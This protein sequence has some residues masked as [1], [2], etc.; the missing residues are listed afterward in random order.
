MQLAALS[1]YIFTL[2]LTATYVH[3]A[4]PQVDFDRMGTVA[5]AGTFSGLDV[6][7]NNSS[8]T[9]DSS[10]SSVFARSPSG[11]LTYLGSTNA[12]GRVS[13]GCFLG[14]LF[15]LTGSFFSFADVPAANVV[16]YSFGSGRFMALGSG[17]PN[18]PVD[19]ILC[20][21]KIDRVW[22]GGSFTSPGSS[23]AIWDPRSTSWSS[24][25]FS[26]FSGA[27]SRVHSITT[28]SSSSSIF[29]A[30]SFVTNFQGNGTSVDDINN[31]NVPFS[32]G[33]TALSSSL[34]PIPLRDA[35]VIGSP[36]SS[37]SQFNN[38]QNVL[39]PT[40][41][42]GP[43][44][45]WFAAEGNSPLITVR[46]FSFISVNGVRLG[47]TFL[48]NHGT[49]GFSVTTI[50]DNKLQNLHFKDPA[51]G[52]MQTCSDPCPLSTNSSLLYQD[53]LFDDILSI[54]GVQINLSGFTGVASG[55]HILQLLSSGAFVSA[56][57]TD[58]GLSCFASSS[59]NVT[60][61]G[62]WAVQV[63]NTGIPGT[64]QRVAVANVNVGT[65]PASGPSFAWHPFI[66]AFG[67]YDVNLLVPGCANLQDCSARTT[68]KIT[69][70][71]E[72]GV[73]PQVTTVS[74]Q[75]TEDA[76]ITVYSGT[77]S[78]SSSNF[79]PTITMTLA[80]APV[81]SGQ[82]G[83]F[84]LVADRVQ[85][86]LKTPNPGESAESPRGRRGS[87]MGFGF[88]EWPSATAGTSINATSIVPISSTTSLDD[89]GIGFF[90]GIRKENTSSFASETVITAVAHHPSGLIFLGGNFALSS[91]SASGGA[92]I[93]AFNGSL[94]N[95]AGNGLNGPV[96][97]LLLDGNL[98]FV[99]GGFTGTLSSSD[100]RKLRGIAVY[101]VNQSD[102]SPLGAG[103]DG[104]VTSLNLKNGQL[105]VVGNF[106][107]VFTAD[108]ASADAAGFAVW[109]IRKRA[110]VNSGGFVM[111]GM[112][113]IGNG[114]STIQVLAG[115]VIAAR[116]YGASG[117][118]FL[119][120][121]DSNGPVV[122]PLGAQLQN[123]NTTFRPSL[124]SQ[125]RRSPYLLSTSDSVWS[126]IISRQ[127]NLTTQMPTLPAP[128]PALS[129]SILTGAF[130]TNSSSSTDIFVL[131]GNFSLHV[132]DTSM[133]FQCIALYSLSSASIFGLVGSQI[134]GLVRTLLVDGNKLYIGGEFRIQDTDVNGLA[135]YDLSRQEWSTTG[136]QPLQPSD[137]NN[138]V[139]RSISKSTSRPNTIIVAGSFSRAGSLPCAA[140]CSY[141][142]TSQ[143]WTS[144]GT[145]LRGEI[146][147]VSYA[148]SNQDI[149]VVSG[150]IRLAD[151]TVSNVAQ[152]SFVNATW[153]PLGTAT[154]LPGPV[155]AVEV[156]NK[157]SS[158]IFA[159]GQSSDRA[160]TFLSF[161]NGVTWTNLDSNLRG[162]STITQLTMVPLQDTHPN[163]DVIAG[164]RVLLISGLLDSSS[165][166]VASCAL[167]DGRSFI[168]YIL[169][170]TAT[171]TPGIVSSVLRSISSFSFGR[172]RFLATG[173]V[174]LISIAISAGLIFMLALIGIVWTILSRRDDKFDKL[175]GVDP[176]EDG[177]VHHR[178]SSLLEH[179]NAA[180]RKTILLD[181]TTEG[182]GEKFPE[183]IQD[184][185]SPDE[186][187]YIRPG[188]PAGI[189]AAEETSRPA[190]A[191]YSFDGTGEGELPISAGVEVD[192][193]DDHDP[194]WW[195][196]RDVRTG[197][198]GVVP[199]AYLY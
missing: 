29:F 159:A 140:I 149:L 186:S 19:A 15:Y 60:T 46:T 80:D 133:V 74:Q 134:D 55:L 98:L 96:T 125:R 16:S 163:T 164:D 152:F 181:N 145:G 44:N 91:G 178:P 127:V 56:I 57:D 20:D 31:P 153:I 122:A 21:S 148:G 11:A 132:P 173:V 105:Q 82:N 62:N 114:S 52:Q 40:G 75:N 194:A 180:T 112:T 191:R 113:Y 196:A 17:G 53:F 136:L 193:L 34:V 130:W 38:I 78:S 151:E 67:D 198:E 30:G 49:T 87:K 143:Q 63:A 104:E 61:N 118:V 166:G 120:N 187:N 45:T 94:R 199:A 85:L 68:A 157:N 155:T 141:D 156:N 39:C 42:D 27:E 165:F 100:A 129:P 107:H 93:I 176:D 25:P 26:S 86:I 189:I 124:N 106:T 116:Q 144:L 4:L 138:V 28:N 150:S 146:A 126:E 76:A 50:P 102:W 161:W 7:G 81:G 169:S 92:N 22:V 171:G 83:Q 197:R 99:G 172:R 37:D 121:G 142:L 47:N 188:S 137:G 101:D 72:E 90:E 89:I 12:G 154:D 131:G 5:L 192:V 54:T 135:I 183:D 184:P 48:Q 71:L 18:G 35:Q 84:N 23:V 32:A 69:I 177:S 175:D 73:P 95:L 36:S 14:S 195:Y 185:F 79:V 8:I 170:T 174:I 162:N 182:Q 58:N 88:F 115:N 41:P 109:D 123:I 1:S 66:S 33:A 3:A 111:G 43:G 167:F 77:I 97:S 119:R 9:Y 117:M 168:P 147:A 13:A 64:T 110:W 70:S 190:R 2:T 158:S 108:D 65:S 10:T 128:P 160:S 51:T 59:S 103:L 139:V 6:F 179:I 24:P